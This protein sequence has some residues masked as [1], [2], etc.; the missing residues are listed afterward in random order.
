METFKVDKQGFVVKC[1]RKGCKNKP[2]NKCKF[3]SKTSKFN[4]RRCAEGKPIEKRPVKQDNFKKS[5][6]YLRI[7]KDKA[8]LEEKIIKALGELKFSSVVS[9]NLDIKIFYR[10]VTSNLNINKKEENE[11]E[12]PKFSFGEA[13]TCLFSDGEVEE[14]L[15]ELPEIFQEENEPNL[16]VHDLEIRNIIH[17]NINN[18]NNDSDISP[19][20]ERRFSLNELRIILKLLK[21]KLNFFI[22]DTAMGKFLGK[23][24]GLDYSIKYWIIKCF[25]QILFNKVRNYFE[26]KTFN[27]QEPNG[28]I[29]K[30]SFLNVRKLIQYLILNQFKFADKEVKILISGDGRKSSKRTNFTVL[31]MKILT[32]QTHSPNDVHTIAIV[33]TSESYETIKQLF[34]VVNE[35]LK[36]VAINGIQILEAKYKVKF[37]FCSDWKFLA[38][39]LGLNAANSKYFCPWC[40]CTKISFRYS[41]IANYSKLYRTLPNMK[42]GSCPNCKPIEK[43]SE[44]T[45]TLSDE[46]FIDLSIEIDSNVI[47]DEIV[48]NFDG[49][50]F[51]PITS[52][53]EI[54]PPSNSIS[55]AVTI[56]P[57]N[58]EID[59]ENLLLNDEMI[60]SD[61]KCD[62]EHGVIHD[63]LLLCQ[64]FVISHIFM[65]LL[66]ALLRITDVVE[67]YLFIKIFQAKKVKEFVQAVWE[68]CGFRW[69]PY[70]T[71]EKKVEKIVFPSL[72]GKL[73]KKLFNLQ[74]LTFITSGNTFVSCFQQIGCLFSYLECPKGS[75]TTCTHNIKSPKDYQREIMKLK[76]L[77]YMIGNEKALTPYF[78]GMEIHV[79]VMIKSAPGNSLSQFNLSSQEAKHKVETAIQFR[80]S[81]QIDCVSQ[82]LVHESA[83]LYVNY[84]D[85]TNF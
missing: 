61:E 47:N 55:D 16:E 72:D 66:H 40:T 83:L 13:A 85:L 84:I 29:I 62:P 31:T 19:K 80:A 11:M 65:D 30:G 7:K 15:L 41:D 26:I 46:I 63:C 10:D 44:P 35:E 77:F 4:C 54:V 45:I 67:K 33:E 58:S 53:M 70:S 38:L 79:P 73:K 68:Q 6:V 27:F 25:K 51:P 28:N 8:E 36:N 3:D 43:E 82:I 71:K 59:V 1:I 57:I 69:I 76:R 20:S 81:N 5:T 18:L 24:E 14:L 21:L 17:N 74:T 48:T 37:F 9:Y 39:S 42:G 78:H 56:P 34:S 50:T 32:D 2:M 60:P 12:K 75:H 64:I 23:K 49:F 22:S 52:E